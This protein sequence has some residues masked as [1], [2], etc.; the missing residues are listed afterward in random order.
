VE[1]GWLRYASTT[2]PGAVWIAGVG[3]WLLDRSFGR[4]RRDPRAA[5]LAPPR[6][7]LVTFLLVT[8]SQLHAALDRVYKLASS[9]PEAPL[10]RFRAK[11]RGLPQS[12]E[13]ERLVVQR[14]GQDIFRDALMD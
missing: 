4:R 6:A 11:T 13:A 9:L 1:E 7:G 5:G 12:T 14:V 10:N 3:P 8:L 2:A